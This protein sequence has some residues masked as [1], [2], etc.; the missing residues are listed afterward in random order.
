MITRRTF[1]KFGLAA[2]V[3]RE[4]FASPQV[5]GTAKSVIW[6]WMGGGL[7]QT[8]TWDPK[9]NQP[10]KAVATAV[11]GIEIS[12]ALPVCAAQMKHLAIVRT[13]AHG[14]GESRR[15]T[16]Y[17]HTGFPDPEAYDAI[18]PVGEIVARELGQKGSPIPRYVAIDPP[19]IPAS[20][21]FGEETLP[22]RIVNL[23][24]PLP[25]SGVEPDRD[26]AR[27]ALLAEEDAEWSGTRRQPPVERLLRARAR[28]AD[29]LD[30]PFRKAFDLSGE[31]EA[32]RRAYG[33]LFG[34]NC[35]LA[36][37]LVQAECVFVEV[38]L[39]G[40]GMRDDVFG[41]AKRMIPTLDRGLG[42][43]VRDLDEKGLLKETLVVCATEFGKTPDIN[44]G[45]GRDPWAD[46]FS[47]ALAGGGIQGGRV[48][49]DTGPTGTKPV[50]RVPV[51]RFLGTVYAACGIDA[52]RNYDRV[53]RK[54][55]VVPVGD[56]TPLKEI[57]A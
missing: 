42:T 32:L 25:G 21:V 47:V 23:D 26:K 3:P 17:M 45:N 2:A 31:P 53:E 16:F 37:R 35:L 18:P 11:P 51:S 54:F 27:E 10:F 56:A 55:K 50:R 9:P 12:E 22:F 38:G 1:L 33:D 15:A 29:L 7:P 13:L 49:G 30:S 24:D 39:G 40:W 36:R 41:A 52:N 5:R 14:I 48:Y 8:D 34:I 46:G 43:L 4:A 20:G 57:F 44:G 19:R 6:L 28:A